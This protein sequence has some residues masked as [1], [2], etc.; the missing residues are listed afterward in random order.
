MTSPLAA[1]AVEI[2]D[3]WQ[4]R[5]GRQGDLLLVKPYDIVAETLCSTLVSIRR[6]HSF[7]DC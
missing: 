1:A 7:S 2:S 4:R 3:D 5:V 6:L